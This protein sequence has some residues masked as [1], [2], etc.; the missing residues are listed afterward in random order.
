MTQLNKHIIFYYRIYYQ[1]MTPFNLEK[2][3]KCL[4]ISL[5]GPKYTKIGGIDPKTSIRKLIKD[6]IIGIDQ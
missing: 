4:F 5:F 6:W 3:L 1:T 2:C